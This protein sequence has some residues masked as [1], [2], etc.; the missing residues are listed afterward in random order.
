MVEWLIQKG[1]NPNIPN[2][3]GDTSLHV[4]AK[5]GTREIAECLVG[6]GGGDVNHANGRGDTPLHY[7][8]IN[9]NRVMVQYLIEQGAEIN[10]PNNYGNTPIMAAVDLGDHKQE[11]VEEW[12]SNKTAHF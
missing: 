2:G 7:A 4:A 8:A 12:F 1:A 3:H 9:G 5:W 10:R 11:E 6:Q